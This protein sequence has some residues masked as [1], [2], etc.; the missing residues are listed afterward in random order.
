[1]Y[2]F[3]NEVKMPPIV[4]AEKCVIGAAETCPKQAIEKFVQFMRNFSMGCLIF[5][6][7]LYVFTVR[8]SS[9]PKKFTNRSE[10]F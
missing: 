8:I 10:L 2:G 6:R 9:P 5:C 1:M 3:E 4:P 7:F